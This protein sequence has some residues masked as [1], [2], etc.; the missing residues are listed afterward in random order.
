VGLAPSQA[1][2]TPSKAAEPR[3]ELHVVGWDRPWWVALGGTMLT[4]D[5]TRLAL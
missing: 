1:G 3:T 5:P 2:M 4:D